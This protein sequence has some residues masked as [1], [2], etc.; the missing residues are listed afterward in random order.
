[1]SKKK[2]KRKTKKK[3]AKKKA[4]DKLSINVVRDAAKKRRTEEEELAEK[5][6][7]EVLESVPDEVAANYDPEPEATPN[8]RAIVYGGKPRGGS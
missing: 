7:P 1:M 5:Y 3:A 8:H 2:A 4:I 6:G